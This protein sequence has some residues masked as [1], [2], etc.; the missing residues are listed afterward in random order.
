[1]KCFDYHNIAEIN[2]TQC[3]NMVNQLYG[4]SI[5]RKIDRHSVKF[6]RI[7]EP[8][9]VEEK[10]RKKA[11]LYFVITHIALDHKQ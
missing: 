8:E 10:T 7:F 4:K 3:K 6:C 1:M 11:G 9:S 2:R 5:E